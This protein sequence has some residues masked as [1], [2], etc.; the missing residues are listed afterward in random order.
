MPVYTFYCCRPDESAPSFEARDLQS[1]EAAAQHARAMLQEHRSC[2]HVVV[3]L[4][5]EEVL[6]ARREREQPYLSP[7]EEARPGL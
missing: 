5:D 7:D 1:D 2:S 4:E 6:T 3:C